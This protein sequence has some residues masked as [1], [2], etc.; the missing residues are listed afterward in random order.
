MNTKTTNKNVTIKPSGQTVLTPDERAAEIR[1]KHEATERKSRKAFVQKHVTSLANGSIE[2]L[3]L[4]PLQEVIQ[5][6]FKK[7]LQFA[8]A[9][10]G[11]A[12]AW[13]TAW[14]EAQQKRVVIRVGDTDCKIWD[15]NTVETWTDAT[16][17]DLI[18][19]WVKPDSLRKGLESVT[20][21]LIHGVT[22]IVDLALGKKDCSDNGRHLDAF[23]ETAKQLG[24]IVSKVET[25]KRYELNSLNPAGQAWLAGS[26]IDSSKII[27]WGK[28]EVAKAEGKKRGGGNNTAK[29]NK[30]K[31]KKQAD[32][33]KLN[34]SKASK[35]DN[36]MKQVEQVFCPVKSHVSKHGLTLV[37]KGKT[38]VCP[39]S[40]AKDNPASRCLKV[41]TTTNPKNDKK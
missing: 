13:F 15:S 39:V 24:A 14:T 33:K 21:D 35:Y 4:V 37:A 7:Y 30:A 1:R 41:M 40:T 23:M 12:P 31:A 5:D 3:D 10:G 9:Q 6:N 16:N 34:A 20:C 38:H 32:A 25:N 28:A 8:S 36:L 18:V 22:H 11:F 19:L 27:A 17:T 29:A 2:I 26:G